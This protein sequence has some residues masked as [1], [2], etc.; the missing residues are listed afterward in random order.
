MQLPCNQG[1]EGRKKTNRKKIDTKTA[2]RLSK[3][4]KAETSSVDAALR[5][6][7][8][9]HW[10]VP[11]LFSGGLLHPGGVPSNDVC[12]MTSHRR[13]SGPT[14]GLPANLQPP[15]ASPYTHI[16]QLNWR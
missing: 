7:Q 5:R 14:G 1:L 8:S 15:G 3:T 16:G 2:P 12:F 11:G 13:M 6:P 10:T 9:P 4:L